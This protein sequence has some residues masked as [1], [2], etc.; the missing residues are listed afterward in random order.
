MRRSSWSVTTPCTEVKG[1]PRRRIRI[2]RLIIRAVDRLQTLCRISNPEMAT[3]ARR[4]S[5]GMVK[6]CEQKNW[7]QKKKNQ[8]PR[9]D[10][11]SDRG[12]TFGP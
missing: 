2:H 9:L 1:S 12:S 7:R 6:S 5:S 11:A 4:R 3:A 10:R 8:P